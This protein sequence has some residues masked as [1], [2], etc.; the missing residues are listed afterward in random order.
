MAKNVTLRVKNGKLIC[1]NN[2]IHLSFKKSSS[3]SLKQILNEC[4]VK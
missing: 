2:K 1:N 3:K 4:G